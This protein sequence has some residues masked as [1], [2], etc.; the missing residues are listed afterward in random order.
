MWNTRNFKLESAPESFGLQ[1]DSLN[2]KEMG[3]GI[4]HNLEVSHETEGSSQGSKYNNLPEE[5]KEKIEQILF[6]LDKFCVGDAFY[7]ELTMT[8]EGLPRSYLVKQ[9]RDNLNKLCHIMTL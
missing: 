2:V 8:F 9:C 3:T 1:L 4:V 7:H 6:L 5:E